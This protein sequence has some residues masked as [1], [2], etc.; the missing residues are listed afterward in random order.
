MDSG[1]Y[2]HMDSPL[3]LLV[4]A[5]DDH[6]LRALRMGPDAHPEPRWTRD[7]G[8][9]YS[10]RHQLQEYFAGERQAFTLNVQPEGTAFQRQVWTALCGIPYGQTISYGALARRVGSPGGARAVGGANGRNPIPIIIPCHRV[11]N[12]DGGLGG[13][14]SGLEAKR[15]LLTLEGQFGAQAGL[16]LR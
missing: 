8:R 13:Y 16:D 4:M 5:C 7:P 15:C 14:S 11:I 6:G 10:V 1:Y 9:L 3:G 2:D 12:A